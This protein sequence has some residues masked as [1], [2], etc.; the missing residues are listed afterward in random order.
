MAPFRV[1]H[2]LPFAALLLVSSGCA[3]SQGVPADV[4]SPLPEDHAA[5]DGY[6][7]GLTVLHLVGSPAEYDGRSES[8]TGLFTYQFEDVSLAFSDAPEFNHPSL[9]LW[10]DFAPGC[11][12]VRRVDVHGRFDRHNHGHMGVYFGGLTVGYISFE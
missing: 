1:K 5:A 4:G 10:L 12:L 9:V 8:V 11:R 3:H 7:D 2:L 6:I